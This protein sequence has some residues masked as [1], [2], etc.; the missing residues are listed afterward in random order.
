MRNDL[1]ERHIP[2]PL[3][4]LGPGLRAANSI[5]QSRDKLIRTRY[6]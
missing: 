5:L 3:T 1:T 2:R 6:R 4:A